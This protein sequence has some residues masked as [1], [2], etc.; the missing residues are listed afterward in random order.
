[1][2]SSS[3][4]PSSPF[5]RNQSE[6]FPHSVA[7]LHGNQQTKSNKNKQTSSK[8]AQT[9]TQHAVRIVFICTILLFS[10]TERCQAQ[11]LQGIADGL[12]ARWFESASSLSYLP[13][14]SFYEN[15]TPSL[16]NTVPNIN[17]ALVGNRQ[18][19]GLNAV[20]GGLLNRYSVRFDGFVAIS[21]SGDW[22]FCTTSDDGSRIIL[23][24]TL[25]VNNDG[26]HRMIEVCATRTVAR[27][28]YAIVVDFFEDDGEQGLIVAWSGPGVA[29]QAVPPSALR[30]NLCAAGTF[31]NS[32]SQQF[33]C[34]ACSRGASCPSA[35]M[36]A[37]VPCEAGKYQDISGSSN[38]KVC[39]PGSLC[40][41][42]GLVAPNGVCPVGSF[43]PAGA[44]T[45]T[46]C[47]PGS[48]CQTIGLPQPEPCPSGNYCPS[49]GMVN[50]GVACKVGSYCPA[51]SSS[52]V[53][54][55]AG[56]YCP[57]SAMSSPVLCPAGSY[58]PNKGMPSHIPC[59][60]GHTCSAG[61]VQPQADSESSSHPEWAIALEVISG[62]ISV[63][64]AVWKCCRKSG[65]GFSSGDSY[66]V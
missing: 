66:T 31:Q 19:G 57:A 35:G 64:G 25:L 8:Q 18:S 61:C 22:T 32:T 34:T 6:T 46:I 38:C 24:G 49:T 60:S 7:R 20:T 54:C 3:I 9:I 27:G 39:S 41:T 33:S 16:V 47:P 62:L 11:S 23:N 42:A 12:R 45:P 13:S 63:G 44:S 50:G 59:P 2:H 14:E 53:Q 52:A 55:P 1:M 37:P 58:C 26:R 21:S 10:Q 28:Q 51:G 56:S 15:R 17:Y 65:R 40:S 36:S 29:K 48:Y 30:C 4:Q 43:C 5:A